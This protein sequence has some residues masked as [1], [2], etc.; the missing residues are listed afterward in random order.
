MGWGF[1]FGLI[2]P[3]DNEI[4]SLVFGEKKKK[5][6]NSNGVIELQLASK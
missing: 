4:C 6:E 3:W 1:A 2:W 5:Q